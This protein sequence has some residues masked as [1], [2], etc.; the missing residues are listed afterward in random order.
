MTQFT[1]ELLNFLAQKQDIDEFFRSFLEAK[2][3]VEVS[4]F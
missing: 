3:Q 4:Q 2:F 1:T